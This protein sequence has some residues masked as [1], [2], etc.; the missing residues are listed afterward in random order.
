MNLHTGLAA[1]F[2]TLG[3]IAPL[4]VRRS[5]PW[6]R[7]GVK[8]AVFAAISVTLPFVVG[9]PLH[10]HFDAEPG[11]QVLEQLLEAAW[12]LMAGR[13]LVGAG[14]AFVVV[15][16]RP[17]ETR[18][19][20]D[21]L[22][23]LVYV[24]TALAIVNFAFDVPVRGLLATS[25]II[26][27]VLG[28][29]LQST[30]SDVFS[31]VA[32][33]V[34][35]PYELG[36]MVWFEGGI[37]GRVVLV[38]WRSTHVQTG[39]DDI[40]ILPNSVVAKSRLINR[41]HPTPV[42]SETVAV[43]LN[44][45]APPERCLAILANA[46]QSCRHLQAHPA[47]SVSIGTLAGDGIRY[48]VSYAVSDS[49]LIVAA[50]TELLGQIHRHLRF[51]GIGFAVPGLPAPDVQPA[52]GP[53]A[54]LEASDHFS[55]LPEKDRDG[56]AAHLVERTFAPGDVL[57]QQ[58]NAR[59]VFIIGSGT[60]AITSTIDGEVRRL[61]TLSPGMFIGLVGLLVGEPY[62]VVATVLTRCT[63]YEL[64]GDDLKAIMARYPRLA[65]A[66]VQTAQQI[67]ASLAA[68]VTMPVLPPAQHDDQ[69]IE[70]LRAFFGLSRA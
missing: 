12:W 35:R 9:S 34:E 29:A 56:I 21:L 10:P 30:M 42:R 63:A 15:E 47:P 41:S 17:R 36:D 3:L 18:L 53:R 50:R 44:S 49:N 60:V 68:D 40:A 20:S 16:N 19:V 37:E 64:P 6:V 58:G 7:L 65:D 33:G 57:Q 14:R 23:G 1:G 52:A 45:K 38:T 13:A 5:A 62:G 43:V 69:L 24:C 8:T 59:S 22:A 46:A 31:G 67:H 28:L 32:L 11:E 27:I 54:L 55:A 39:D 61:G 26:A 66:L 51:T 4:L 2:A 70:R 25:G 48:V